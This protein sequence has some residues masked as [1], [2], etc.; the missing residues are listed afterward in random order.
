MGNRFHSVTL[1]TD[2]CKGC[3]NCILEGFGACF[4]SVNSRSHHF[5][6]ENIEALALYILC[7]HVDITLH[8]KLSCGCRSCH[9]M[10][11]GSSFSDDS[12]LAH[13]LS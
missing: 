8:T 6:T 5:H 4:H 10:L 9:T 13:T 1:D 2:A 12:S 3:I 7:P 11:A